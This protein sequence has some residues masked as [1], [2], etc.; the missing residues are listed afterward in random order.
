MVK[1]KQRA[2]SVK[3]RDIGT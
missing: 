2:W 1:I 3:Q